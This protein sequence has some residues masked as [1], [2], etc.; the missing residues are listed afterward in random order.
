MCNRAGDSS[1]ISDKSAYERAYNKE[2][3]RGS[4]T[5]NMLEGIQE[6]IC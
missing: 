5:K 3:V 4:T 1:S 6:K 2:Y